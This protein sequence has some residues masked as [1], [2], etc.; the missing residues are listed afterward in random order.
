MSIDFA[1]LEENFF[2]QKLDEEQK[3]VLSTKIEAVEYAAGSIIVKQGSMGQAL[4]VVHSGIAKIQ[5][6]NNGETIT[7][8]TVHP[9]DLIGEMSFLTAAET[10]ATVTARDDCVIYKLPR[11]AFS[12]LMKEN[13]ELAYAV[14]AHLL[15]HTANVIRQM[16]AEKAAVQ[17]YM[18]GSRF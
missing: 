5:C 15:T 11:H 2:K 9:G 3:S 17:H 16:N 8:G 13:Q 6:D 1:W 7:V 4:Y 18:A 10:S 14:F 12:S